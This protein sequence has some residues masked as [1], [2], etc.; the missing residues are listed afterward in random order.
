[1]L[2]EHKF[3]DKQSLYEALSLGIAQDLQASLAE[4]DKALFLV[5]GGSSPA[6]VYRT[7]STKQ[8][9]W[10]HVDVALVDE[11]WVNPGE[12]GSNQTL[13]ENSL[14]QNHAVDAN[15]TAMKNGAGTADQGLAQCETD[16]SALAWEQSVALLGMGPDGHTASLFPDAE[17][18]HRALVSDDYCA[19]IT[20]K[21]SE[22]TGSLTERMSLTLSALARCK[23]LYLLISGAEKWQV[24]D[25]AKA[26]SKNIS[27]DSLVIANLLAR[28]D[29]ELNVFW[30]P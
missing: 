23:R 25:E 11:R 28:S 2:L 22:V 19:A 10:S 30:A 24:F 14:L 15:F 17:G 18:L 20:A 12:Q 5:S 1:M 4:D 3:E 16:Y 7:L 9:R 27:G 21:E 8:L 29:I 6:P 13:I 26:Q